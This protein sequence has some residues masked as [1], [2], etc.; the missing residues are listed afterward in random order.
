MFWSTEF[1]F[2]LLKYHLDQ[3]DGFKAFSKD[4]IDQSAD[5]STLVLSPRVVGISLQGAAFM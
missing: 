4:D 5:L 3:N 1:I 2:L